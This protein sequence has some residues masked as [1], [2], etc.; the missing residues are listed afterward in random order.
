MALDCFD[1]LLRLDRTC[2][3]GSGVVGLGAV[4]IDETLLAAFT[5]PEDTVSG[6]LAEA[7]QYAR[8][9][10]QSDVLTYHSRSIIP[11]TLVDRK[12]IG[13][14]DDTRTLVSGETGS[15]GVL[16]TVD[17][18]GSN[19]VLRLSS[20][21]FYGGSTGIV[22]F[23]VTDM[24]DGH[25]V[26]TFNVQAVSGQVVN[27]PITVMIPVY[28]RRRSFLVHHAQT[29]WYRTT[30]A[31]SC[32]SC[33]SCSYDVNGLTI[34]GARLPQGSAMVRSNL[35]TSCLTS[36]VGITASLAC[37]HGQMLCEYRDALVLPYMEKVAE[38][39]LR[40]GLAAY[41]RVNAP[42]MDREQL[43][44]RADRHGAAYAAAMENVVRGMRTPLD[45]VC[46]VCYRNAESRVALP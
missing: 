18:R 44:A 1:G 41:T 45:P 34:T 5:G 37:D 16:L 10:M 42:R 7:E 35:R 17:P 43:E 46:W 27:T 30:M 38:T 19:L 6:M 13:H 36:G 31:G 9:V 8:M 39:L 40:R 11:R 29:S 25:A 21:D 20:I 23:T 12:T 4:G 2:P 14:P 24:T 32:A 22:T 33:G 28:G 15:G 3:P 26:T